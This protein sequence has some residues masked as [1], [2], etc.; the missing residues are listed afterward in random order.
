MC[1]I[2]DVDI[3]DTTPGQDELTNRIAGSAG[4]NLSVIFRKER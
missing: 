1:G 2:S 4:K 3:V